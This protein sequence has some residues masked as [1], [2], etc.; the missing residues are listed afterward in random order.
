[1]YTPTVSLQRLLKASCAS[2]FILTGVAVATPANA[3]SVFMDE[4]VVTAQKREQNLQ[5]VGIAVTAYS[6][7]QL[8]SLGFT[9][10]IDLIAQTPG[11]EA[12]GYG[13]GAITSFVVRG[14]GQNDFT[15]NQEAPVALYIDGA[16][17]SSNVTNLF[18]LFDIERAEILRGPQGT[19]YGRNATGGLVHYITTKPS[20][21]LEGYLDLTAGEQGRVKVEAA[22][23]GALSEKVSGR[24][25]FNMN[26]DNGLLENDL[27]ENTMRQKNVA[28]RAQLLIDPTEDVSILLKAQYGEENGSPG[29]YSTDLP[30][31]STTDF[32]GNPSSASDGDPYTISNDYESFSKTDVLD[33]SANV[34][35]DIGNGIV[36]TSLTNYQDINAGYGEDTDSSASSAYHYTQQADIKQFSQ[37]L[38]VSIDGEGYSAVIGGYF[39]NIDGGFSIDQFGDIYFGPGTVFNINADQKTSTY[40]IFGQVEYALSD[41]LSLTVGLRYNYDKKEY[42]LTAPDYGFATFNGKFS[43]SDWSGKIQLDYQAS[44][45][46]LVYAGVNRGIKSGGYNLPLTPADPSVLEYGGEVLTSIEGGV[47]SSLGERTRLNISAY[48]YDYNDYQAYNIDPYFNALIFNAEAKMHGG[49]IELTTSPVDGLDILLGMSYVDTEVSGLPVLLYPGGTSEAALSP[50]LTFNGL[51][52]YAW[53]LF[54]GEA[55]V[56]GDFSWRDDHTFNLAVSDPVVEGSYGVINLRLGYTSSNEVWSASVFVKN[57]TNTRYRRFAVDGTAFFGTFENILGDKRWFGGNVRFN[58]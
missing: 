19:L 29:G 15:P 37:E 5:E 56:Q 10:S 54:D 27:N 58:F 30:S 3:Q 53:P 34:E 40:A 13:G 1:M 32:F 39:L 50:K 44:E 14:V 16:Y 25:S 55:S 6:G 9:N 24:V 26:R 36:L 49:E 38:R 47:K 20:Q 43:D 35:A 4:I 51:V 2:A 8:R 45:N 18:S 48:Y 52:R 17:Q 57:L 23:G 41:L 22:V 11:L 12:S 21:E 7:D 46:V 42:V 33:L 28:V 31:G